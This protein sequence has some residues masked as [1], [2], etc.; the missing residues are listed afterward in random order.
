MPELGL[1]LF[2]FIWPPDF[3]EPQVRIYMI[4]K[5]I[6]RGVTKLSFWKGH[7]SG[8]ILR[9][10]HQIPLVGFFT[11][12]FIISCFNLFLSKIFLCWTSCMHYTVLSVEILQQIYRFFLCERITLHSFM[13]LW[14]VFSVIVLTHSISFYQVVIPLLIGILFSWRVVPMF[15]LLAIKIIL[16]P[17]W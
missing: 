3:L 4:L 17:A 15:I 16:E 9:Q 12:M 10:Q 2:M 6:L 14:L 7:W 1:Y 5:S 13:T 11:T 8:G